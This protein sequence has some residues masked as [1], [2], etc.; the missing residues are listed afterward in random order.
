LHAGWVGLPLN[1]LQFLFV[2][3]ALHLLIVSQPVKLALDFD[4]LSALRWCKLGM[5]LVE[6]I[7]ISLKPVDVVL[8]SDVVQSVNISTKAAA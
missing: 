6:V 1:P 2:C 8:A 4:S 7:E 5:L 3:K